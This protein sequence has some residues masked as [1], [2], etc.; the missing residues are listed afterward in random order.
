MQWCHPAAIAPEQGYRSRLEA[1][2]LPNALVQHVARL[3]RGCRTG[4]P[5]AH[6]GARSARCVRAG[7]PRDPATRRNQSYGSDSTAF[8][9]P[10][11]AVFSTS[12][13]IYFRRQ[14]TVSNN[15]MITILV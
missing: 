3:D 7:E 11:L 2:M 15:Q 1:A 12:G 8:A 10:S 14:L 9:A 5:P 4:S 6:C 13:G